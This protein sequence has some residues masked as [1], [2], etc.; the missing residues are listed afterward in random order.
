MKTHRDTSF[1]YFPWDIAFASGFPII[2]PFLLLAVLH[3]VPNSGLLI[4]VIFSS[5]VA[6]AGGVVMSWAKIPLYRQGRFLTIGPKGLDERRTQFY[7]VGFRIA[8]LGLIA[9]AVLFLVLWM[10]N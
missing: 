2:L 8:I 7:K 10:P 9:E 3:S 4:L 6:F 5:C 1:R